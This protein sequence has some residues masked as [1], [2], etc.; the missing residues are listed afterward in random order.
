MLARIEGVVDVTPGGR[1]GD[2]WTVAV[3]PASQEANVRR[4]IIVL[5]AREAL[6]LMSLRP[7][8][9]SLD[10]IYRHAVHTL[11]PSMPGAIA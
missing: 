11:G 4:A 6:P 1:V 8:V 7:V 10:E 3:K 9:A 2:P 5:A